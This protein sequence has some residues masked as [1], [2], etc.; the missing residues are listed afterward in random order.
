MQCSSRSIVLR[1]S[2]CLPATSRRLTR[3]PAELGEGVDITGGVGSA[4]SQALA[5]IAHAALTVTLAAPR[6]CW[7]FMRSSSGLAAWVV[8]AGFAVALGVC[9]LLAGRGGPGDA[10]AD[11]AGFGA[12]PDRGFRGVPAAAGFHD[13]DVRRVLLVH[14]ARALCGRLPGRMHIVL[15]AV[16]ARRSR[17]DLFAAARYRQRPAISS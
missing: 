12:E 9:I 7:N 6:T 4:V 2:T 5:L 15:G 11:R 14:R 3:R 1:H 17:N 13:R 16:S 8:L 10:V